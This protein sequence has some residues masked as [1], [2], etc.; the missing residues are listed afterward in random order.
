MSNLNLL[1]TK[2]TDLQIITWFFF[3]FFFNKAAKR[4]TQ[5]GGHGWLV[6]LV[7]VVSRIPVTGSLFSWTSVWV[8]WLS[9]G[10]DWQFHPRLNLLRTVLKC[11]PDFRLLFSDMQIYSHSLLP[12]CSLISASSSSSASLLHTLP[13]TQSESHSRR[14]K[15]LKPSAG[16]GPRRRLLNAEWEWTGVCEDG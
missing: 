12:L 2:A 10:N 13:I 4:E 1:C 9:H 7:G 5:D 11:F 6:E 14:Q 8:M 16:S 3:F 15:A